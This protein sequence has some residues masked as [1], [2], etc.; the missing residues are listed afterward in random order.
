MM[1]RH[2]DLVL[3]LTSQNR[4]KNG[5]ADGPIIGK[6]PYPYHPPL[7]LFLKLTSDSLSPGPWP[8]SV[9]H[10]LETL[11]QPRYEDFV[12]KHRSR[13]R[14]RYSGDGLA[15]NEAKGLPLGSYVK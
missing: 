9:N 15:P 8:G 12:Y 2:H 11:K 1:K 13:N 4:Y 10:F 3:K 14:F 6:C 7:S 5:S